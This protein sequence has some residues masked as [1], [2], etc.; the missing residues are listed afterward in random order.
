MHTRR[1]G[2]RSAPPLNCGVMRTEQL[3]LCF[4]ALAI[5]LAACASSSAVDVWGDGEFRLSRGQDA[6]NLHFE[7]TE[8]NL[9]AK[10][11]ADALQWLQLQSLVNCPIAPQS[12]RLEDAELV[13]FE[14][15]GA[16]IGV[17]MANPPIGYKFRAEGGRYSC[18]AAEPYDPNDIVVTR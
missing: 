8:L 5:G 7:G 2:Q 9:S 1:A 4:L 13:L 16:S 14:D 17:T 6:E 18:L 11:V 3:Q 10:L 12:F 15:E